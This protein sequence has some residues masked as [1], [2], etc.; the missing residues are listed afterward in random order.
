MRN[1]LLVVT[2]SVVAQSISVAL[3]PVISRLFTPEDFGVFGAFTAV[4]SVLASVVTLDYSQA[5]M[6]PKERDDAGQVFLLSCLVTLVVASLC[7][8]GVVLVGDWWLRILAAESSWLLVL[9]V[10][11]VIAA[12]VN[13]SLQ[14]WCIREKAF[15]LTAA[16]QLVRG[17]SSNGL[18]ILLGAGGFGSAGLIFSTVL[19]DAISSL[20]LLKGTREV[21]R[22]FIE[23]SSWRRLY[24]LAIRYY[25]F[26]LYSATQNL[27]NA[28]STGLP[29]LLLTHYYGAGVA[30]AYAFGSRLLQA[31]MSVL[32]SG[33]RQVLFQ[34]AGEMEH[35]GEAL[36]PLFLKTTLGL[37]A[38]GAGPA[39]VLGL[40]AP[41]LFRL[42]FG[43]QWESAGEF[44][45]YLVVWLLFVFCNLPA[46][47]FARLIRIQH[48]MFVYNSVVLAVRTGV[49][50]VGGPLLTALQTVAAFSLAGAVLNLALI[51]MVG[52][53]LLKRDGPLAAPPWRSGPTVSQ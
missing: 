51:I 9:L 3:S 12:G 35:G 7:A 32:L 13:A 30:G 24:A 19:A 48:K 34:R 39:V 17:V 53:V 46:V 2:S 6:L 14:A 22:R 11:A 1:V 26:P 8:I 52:Q 49:L 5:V 45:R 27:L 31:P 38:I 40:W 21:L 25:D 37:F 16:A 33:L 20:N 44:A 47:L 41:L 36:L 10:F 28:L 29:V 15:R 50:I 43:A 23:R 18:Q 42:V 4:A